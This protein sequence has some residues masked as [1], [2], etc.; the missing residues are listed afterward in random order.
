[1]HEYAPTTTSERDTPAP[2]GHQRL[3]ESVI[4]SKIGQHSQIITGRVCTILGS[5]QLAWRA[6]MGGVSSSGWYVYGPG[7]VGRRRATARLFLRGGPFRMIE[8]NVVGWSALLAPPALVG[9]V[10]ALALG[11]PVAVG[12]LG[13]AGAALVVAVAWDRWRWWNSVA[14]VSS[15]LDLEELR[16]VVE[17]L[18]AEGIE[19]S[20]DAAHQGLAA[21]PAPE[22]QATDCWRLTT[23]QRWVNRVLAALDDASAARPPR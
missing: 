7:S 5:G 1:M 17:R 16:R 6:T 4:G 23:R 2:T 12:A 22:Q 10:G 18:H 19:V 13:G 15:D 3:I 11:S 9:G 21:V 14:S 8:L 20:I